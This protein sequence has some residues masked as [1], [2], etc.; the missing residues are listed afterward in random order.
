M[1]LETLKTKVGLLIEKAQSSGG[2]NTPSKGFVVEEWDNNGF[3][4]KGTAYNMTEIPNAFFQS[5][6]SNEGH[7]FKIT[8]IVFKGNTPTKIG[9]RSFFYC[10]KINFALP[11]TVT[12]VADYAFQHCY[13]FGVNNLNENLITIGES[14]FEYC[15]GSKTAIIPSGVKT[16][17]NKAFAN[18]KITEVK[19]MGT[20][21]TISGTTFG[22][23]NANI[24]N[25]YV[26]WA[27][28]E[29]DNAPW[30]ATSATIHYNTTYDENGNPECPCHP[31]T[32][33]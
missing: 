29:V 33:V 31:A 28:G 17:D 10:T 5:R 18:C 22:T 1:S 13:S 6:A 14:S 3:P 30:G 25:V 32:E 20:P 11:S 16:I 19:F 24:A 7:F 15:Q 26:P 12:E 2:G 9:M 8:D 23:I 4:L 21:V 27:L